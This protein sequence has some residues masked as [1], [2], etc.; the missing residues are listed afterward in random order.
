MNSIND[1]GIGPD[2]ITVPTK[3][4][5]DRVWFRFYGGSL[6]YHFDAWVDEGNSEKINT[7]NTLFNETLTDDQL[8]NQLECYHYHALHSDLSDNWLRHTMLGQQLRDLGFR[9]FAFLERPRA[10]DFETMTP[11]LKCSLLIGL[12]NPVQ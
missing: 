12:L 3:L 5:V 1:D 4:A 11:S 6:T 8:R 9:I 7:L 10:M 2:D